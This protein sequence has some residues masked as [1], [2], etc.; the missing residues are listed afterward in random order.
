MLNRGT[1]IDDLL[2]LHRLRTELRDTARLILRRPRQLG[3]LFNLATGA[4]L[5]FGF[6][7]NTGSLT[8]D[9]LISRVLPCEVARIAVP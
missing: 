5:A 9:A 2:T 4:T 6:S 3:S 1:G 8:T 7:G